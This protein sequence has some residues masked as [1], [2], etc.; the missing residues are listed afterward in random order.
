MRPAGQSSA[1]RFIDQ[2]PR[3]TEFAPGV[4]LA[5]RI[6]TPWSSVNIPLDS[7]KLPPTSWIPGPPE[8]K[9]TEIDLLISEPNLGSGGWPGKNKMGT[10]LI[11]TLPLESGEV[12]WAVHHVINMPNLGKHR[13]RPKFYRGRSIEDLKGKRYRLLLFGNEEEGSRVIYDC[14]V[15]V[16]K[17]DK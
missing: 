11:G 1:G 9:A 8:G 5:F 13:A 14:V 7:G 12:L 15:E 2:W 17:N 4:T 10:Q 6:V 3:P 16:R